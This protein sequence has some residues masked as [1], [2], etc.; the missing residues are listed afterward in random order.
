MCQAP[1]GRIIKVSKNR[2]TVESNG[3]T[4]ELDSKLKDVKEGDYVIFSVNLAIEKVDED[5]AKM[6]LGDL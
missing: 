1:L 4:R 5:E 6:M 2:I 3:K